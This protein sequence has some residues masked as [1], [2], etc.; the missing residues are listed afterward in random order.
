M[1]LFPFMIEVEGHKALVVGAGQSAKE[2]IRALTDFGADV[3]VVAPVIS[4]DVVKQGKNI[5]IERRVY[6]P[7]E[8]K[9]YEIVVAATD[10]QAVNNQVAHD[11]ARFGAIC[12]VA[13]DP[14]RGGFVFPEII[15]K[16][17]F[18]VAVSSDADHE[19][20]EK[21]RERIERALPEKADEIAALFNKARKNMDEFS[22]EDDGSKRRLADMA[23]EDLRT[24]RSDGQEDFDDGSETG[25][26]KISEP[27]KQEL[28]EEGSVIK[29]GT[30]QDRL[31]QAR[32]DSVI[33]RLEAEGYRCSK[34]LFECSGISIALHNDESAAE[35]TTLCNAED[36]LLRGEIDIAVRGAGEIP[37]TLQDGLT[38]AAC[39]PRED[40][41]DVLVTR[42]GT[43]DNEVEVIE[44]DRQSRKAQIEKFLRT[45]E[46]KVSS[47][48]IQVIINRLKAGE[49]DAAVLGASDLSRLLLTDDEE[50]DLEY[51]DVEKSLPVAFEGIVALE[52]RTEGKAHDAAMTLSDHDTMIM[53]GAERAFVRSLGIGREDAA[54]AFSVINSGKLFMKVMIRN[55]QKCVYFAGMDNP[56]N[57][58]QLAEQLA[59]KVRNMTHK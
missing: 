34:V 13:D 19:L 35:Q 5:R 17:S 6:R 55:G 11:A 4:A 9:G 42:K 23:D 1:A 21:I 50:L 10:N 53:L 28:P 8:T 18:S 14:A 57:G 20:A 46:A 38:V 44:T 15:K 59:D 49:T 31:S 41:R 2:K 39:L 30:H 52:T 27:E 56:E 16:K 24:E 37:Q 47:E 29:I 12:T 26:N 48:G 40:S 45:G 58:E 36:A 43:G 51:I 25:E 54:T 7:G 22:P 33:S 32:A 3:T